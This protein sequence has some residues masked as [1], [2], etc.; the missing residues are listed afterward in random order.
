[1]TD[2]AAHGPGTGDAAVDVPRY[3]FVAIDVPVE[4]AEAAANQLFELGA[5]GVEQRDAFTM[6]R[7]AL[8][9]E[10]PKDFGYDVG[11]PVN[12][13]WGGT[14]REPSPGETVTL[15]AAFA[16]REEAEDA[17]SAFDAELNP[18]LEE[19][20]G[21]AWR[22]AWK[23]HFE[24][25]RL[26]RRVVIKPPWRE[27]PAALIAEVPGTIVLELEP[28]RAFGTGL[29]AT[30]SLVAQ[31]LDARE[32]ELRGKELLD[33]GCGSGILALVALVLGADKAR[34]LDID[35]A[36][37][38][39]ANENAQRT[40]LADRFHADTTDVAAV[41]GRWPIVLANIQAEV[42][43]ELK[44]ALAARVL[45]G[46]LLV[47]SGVLE[48]HERAVMDAF[49]DFTLEEATRKGEWVCLVL[50]A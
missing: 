29:H 50:R 15:V 27:V 12:E 6:T 37:T 13:G 21:D 16:T 49:A 39:V 40:G 31:A 34:G 23:V 20:V 41:E 9:P 11:V 26:S 18:R 22:D 28:G 43:V 36:A 2:Q 38:D 32:P 45:P 24:P 46:G 4:L 3:P 8:S 33:V 7:G 17:L 5:E 14:D 48:M 35:E 19:V 47:L 30:T 10:P 42:L 44:P 1:M 25:F